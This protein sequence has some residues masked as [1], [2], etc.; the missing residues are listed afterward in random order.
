MAL[1]ITLLALLLITSVSIVISHVAT[2]ELALVGNYRAENQAFYAADGG[3]EHGLNQLLQIGR[4]R[5]SFP[6]AAEMAA[7]AGPAMAATTFASFQVQAAGPQVTGT[8]VTGFYQGL[9]A[10]TQPFNVAATAE[11]TTVPRGRSSV[12][13]TADFDIIPIFQFAIFYEEDLEIL[14]GP[15][16]LLNGRVHSNADIYIGSNSTLS[17]DSNVTAAGGIYNFRKNDGTAMPG[18]VTVRDA[19]GN[20]LAMA[21]LDST[22]PDW[23]TDALDRWD[24]N[25]RSSEH[26]IERL[27]LTIEDPTTPRK[28]IE[29]AA[30]GDTQADQDAKMWYDA[31]LRIVN[32]RGFDTAGNPVS[33][34][35]PLTGTS[36]IRNTVIFDQREQAFMLTTEVDM[37]KLGRTP[38]YPANGMVYV[39]G[40]EPG[41]GMPAWP[42]G[43]AGVGPAE[44][45]GYDTP[46]A[47][48]GTSEFAVKLTNGAELASRLTVISDNPA[49]VQGNYNSVNKVGAAVIG[50]AVSILSNRWGDVD[51]DGT[52]DDDLAYSQ[53]PLNSRNAQSTTVNAALMMGN[54]DTEPGVRYNGGVENVLRFLE[55]WSGDTLSY[56]GSIIDL[57]NSVHATGDWKYGS[58]IYTAPN[59]DWGFDTDFLDPANLPPGTPNV[60]TIRVIAWERA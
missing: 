15:N 41:N 17:I 34:V 7:I 13:V 44:W 22:D 24:G 42:G 27:N 9:V 28:I 32:D 6:T 16:M 60:Y 12:S 43:G 3:A 26:D 2:S 18:N 31:D 50:D 48:T 14:P 55:R 51:G 5:G 39:G 56:R 20:F 19:A 8:L 23:V 57:W 49:Y 35:D 1:L 53:L 37:A 33:L 40:F 11:T 25:V 54:T 58:P 29:P 45:V 38:G 52:F 46:W 59:R 21:G 4:A 36:A 10:I 47:G 30:P